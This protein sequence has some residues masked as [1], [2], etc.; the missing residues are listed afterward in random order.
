MPF[1]HANCLQLPL[2]PDGTSFSY[3]GDEVELSVWDVET[4]FAPKLQPPPASTTK[5]SQ[6]SETSRKRK[7]STEPLLPRELWREK[8]VCVAAMGHH[9]MH[10]RMGSSQFLPQ[11]FGSV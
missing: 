1:Q 9:D 3:R 8:N 4:A 10:V 7:R 11:P 5:S 6:E 2:A